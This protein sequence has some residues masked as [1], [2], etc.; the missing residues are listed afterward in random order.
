M[1]FCRMAAYAIPRPQKINDT[2][3][4]AMGPKRILE[5]ARYE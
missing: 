2:V 3:I 5:R 1:S 4:R